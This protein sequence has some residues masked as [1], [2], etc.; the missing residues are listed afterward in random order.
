MVKGGIYRVYTTHHGT[1]GC[2]YRGTLP[3]MVHR[4]AQGGYIPPYTHTQGGSGRLYTT[5][6]THREAYTRV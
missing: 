2:I 6:Y 5:L 3:T 4:E 1:E